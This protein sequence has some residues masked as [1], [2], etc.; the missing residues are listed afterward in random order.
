MHYMC[1]CD[2][3]GDITAAA[4]AAA[5][6]IPC[7]RTPAIRGLFNKNGGNNEAGGRNGL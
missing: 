7:L 2:V 4:A 3:G 5:E 6:G 1:Q